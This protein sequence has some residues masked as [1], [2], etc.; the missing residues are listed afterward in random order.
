M[1]LDGLPNVRRDDEDPL[2]ALDVLLLGLNA[3]A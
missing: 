2:L 3:D 1:A